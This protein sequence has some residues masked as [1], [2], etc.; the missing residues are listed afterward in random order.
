[1]RKI[2]LA[3]VVLSSSVVVGSGCIIEARDMGCDSEFDCFSDEVCDPAGF[4][5]DDCVITGCGFSD[6]VCEPASGLCVT[7]PFCDSRFDCFEGEFCGVD[8]LCY[9]YEQTCLGS[10]DCVGDGICVQST[11]DINYECSSSSECPW[12]GSLCNDFG[13]CEY[14]F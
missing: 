3:L 8:G 14:E 1:M 4:C 9:G 5:V 11:C 2:V 13:F 10:A 6:E 7:I 12:V